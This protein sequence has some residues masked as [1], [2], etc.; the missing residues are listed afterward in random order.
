MQLQRFLFVSVFFEGKNNNTIAYWAASSSRIIYRAA[1]V[2]RS[3]RCSV[4]AHIRE[5]EGDT[6]PCLLLFL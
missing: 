2:N 4:L 6:L 5:W 1:V 3:G